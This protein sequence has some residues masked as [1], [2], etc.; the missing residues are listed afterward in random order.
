MREQFAMSTLSQLTNLTWASLADKPVLETGAT[1]FAFL[2][3]RGHLLGV[4]A[5]LVVAV[6]CSLG[7]AA[8]VCPAVHSAPSP[9]GDRR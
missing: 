2:A 1:V 9:P 8:A 4:A 6:P 3:A 7:S 5:V